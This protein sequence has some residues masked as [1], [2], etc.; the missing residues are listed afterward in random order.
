MAIA[1]DYTQ[2]ERVI[3]AFLS[4]YR[5]IDIMRD[6]GL[7]KNIVYKLKKDQKFQRVLKERKQAI[8]Q[9]AVDKM[10]GYMV[11]DVDILQEIIES[12]ETASQVKI[13]AI[14]V[15]FNQ[16][17]EWTTTADIINRLDD[18]E[19]SSEVLKETV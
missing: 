4:N 10:Q 3:G 19:K 13:N 14:Q 9:T 12:P 18:L 11:K 15:L 2:D 5:N 7:S 8:I 17:K 6:T 1:K 16:L